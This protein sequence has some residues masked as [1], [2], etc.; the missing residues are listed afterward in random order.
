M[1]IANPRG[2][3]EEQTRTRLEGFIELLDGKR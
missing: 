2:Y 3:A 1:D